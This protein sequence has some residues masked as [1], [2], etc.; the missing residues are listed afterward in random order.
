MLVARARAL[1]RAAIAN[2]FAHRWALVMRHKDA[3]DF[4]A[5]V[6]ALEAEQTAALAAHTTELVGVVRDERRLSRSWLKARQRIERRRLAHSFRLARYA[7]AIGRYSAF[8]SPDAIRRNRRRQ[9]FALAGR[10][11]TTRTAGVAL[12]LGAPRLT[13]RRGR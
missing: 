7:I 11:V 10:V 9:V 5:K 6:A 3:L 2:R 4:A 12:R 1:A 8:G 13:F